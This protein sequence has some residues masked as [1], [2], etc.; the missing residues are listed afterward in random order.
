MVRMIRISPSYKF[1]TTPQGVVMIGI[2]SII[3][4]LEQFHRI[5]NW[6]FK[7]RK[8]G[9]SFQIGV[10]IDDEKTKWNVIKF[11]MIEETFKKYTG[12]WYEFVYFYLNT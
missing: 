3:T 10:S 11:S 12:I 8:L 2:I 5:I 9:Y 6:K 7:W 4:V 1:V